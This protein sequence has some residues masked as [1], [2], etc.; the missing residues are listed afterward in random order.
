MRS[1]R[2]MG[3]LAALAFSAGPMTA[4]EPPEPRGRA[5]APPAVE[6]LERFRIERLR[7]ALE[8][9]EEQARALRQS[10]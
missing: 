9:D 2:M 4:Q 3:A 1:I 8:L 6:R 7:E 10:L 5:P